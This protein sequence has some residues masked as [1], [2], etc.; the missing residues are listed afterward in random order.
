MRLLG[1][2]MPA[3]L[4]WVSVSVAKI[5]QSLAQA[6]F[7]L[8]G[9]AIV[10]PRLAVVHRI[11]CVGGAPSSPRRGG[12]GRHRA[13]GRLRL[14]HRPGVLDARRRT[15]GSASRLDAFLRPSWARSG[16]G[17]RATRPVAGGS[18]RSACF[19]LGWAV[20][21]AE[22]YLILRWAAAPVDWRTALALET[23]S[24]LIDGILFF[25]P[26]KVGTQEGGKVVLFAAL[27]LSPARG[28]TVGIVRRIREL[29][30]AGLGLLALGWLGARPAAGPGSRAGSCAS[31]D[32]SPCPCLRDPWRSARCSSIRPSFEGFDGGAGSRYQARR[33]IR[34]F[35]YPTWLAQPAALVPGS[36]LVD[37][38]P[39]GLTVEQ[40]APLAREYDQVV[41]HTS[42]PSFGSDLRVAERLKRENPRLLVGMVGAHV[43]VLPEASLRAAGPWTGWG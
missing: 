11:A 2:D 5:G 13:L 35:W 26:A 33:E 6:V 32:R 7:I 24:V 3:S 43:A 9:L 16:R 19:V 30:Y 34:S 42:T 27:G 41:M 25:V 21:A 17:A 36:R 4:R 37:A 1:H 20:G 18:I 39:D 29:A 12:C 31:G 10:L 40:I 15:C 22:V 8:L 28:L 23:G 38:P 14:G